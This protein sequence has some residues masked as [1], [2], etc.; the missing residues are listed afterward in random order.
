[1]VLAGNSW[2]FGLRVLKTLKDGGGGGK[3]RGKGLHGWKGIAKPIS[4][5]ME[6]RG[7]K[8]RGETRDLYACQKMLTPRDTQKKRRESNIHTEISLWTHHGNTT[9]QGWDFGLQ[10][11]LSISGVTPGGERL[12]EKQTKPVSIQGIF[13]K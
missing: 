6:E 2:S 5:V 4:A 13:R 7:R 8:G 1:L 11:P 12:G 10:Y 3:P 9:G